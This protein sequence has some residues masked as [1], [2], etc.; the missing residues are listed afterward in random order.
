MQDCFRF[1]V[2]LLLFAALSPAG[3]HAGDFQ[4]RAMEAALRKTGVSEEKAK[5]VANAADV[6]VEAAREYA[7]NAVSAKPGSPVTS[8]PNPVQPLVSLA[9]DMDTLAC[10][11]LK[12]AVRQAR[13]RLA[14]RMAK[15]MRDFTPQETQLLAK[16][17][18]L[19][20]SVERSCDTSERVETSAKPPPAHSTGAT[21][22]MDGKDADE[23]NGFPPGWTEKDIT[24]L[25]RCMPPHAR[26]LSRTRSSLF[27]MQR[28]LKQQ[29]EK[30]KRL[31]RSQHE[32]YKGQIT[33]CAV[34]YGPLRKAQAKYREMFARLGD[35]IRQMDRYYQDLVVSCIK[36]CPKRVQIALN[37][38][39][40]EAELHI[41]LRNVALGLK[42]P[43]A[44]P[45]CSGPVEIR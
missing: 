13:Q 40:P 20:D 27:E 43:P 12:I 15:D 9:L 17:R 41:Q 23:G 7:R 31:T 5:Q 28:T 22:G 21:P 45:A 32:K 38:R 35:N 3:L 4:K 11:S 19:Q 18:A 16:L 30:L 42:P 10:A 24:C 29:G 26:Y 25:E 34:Y 1:L 8:M 36:R 44:L 14:I 2:T 39:L 33:D 37:K 6:A